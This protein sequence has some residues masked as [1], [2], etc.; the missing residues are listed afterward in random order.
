M[1]KDVN[2]DRSNQDFTALESRVR[3]NLDDQYVELRDS[4]RAILQAV[5]GQRGVHSEEQWEQT[6][7]DARRDYLSGR[8]LIEQLGAER[9]LEPKLMATLSQLRQSLIGKHDPD[10]PAGTMLIDLIVVAYYNA[11]RIQGYIGNLCLVMERELFGQDPLRAVYGD[12][13]GATIEYR[14]KR[15]GEQLLPLQDRAN[16]MMVRNLKALDD[17]TRVPAPTVAVGRAEQVNVGQQQ[18]NQVKA[19]TN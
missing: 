16:R 11:V 19:P 14:L 9:F 10:D 3:N 6:C 1:D 13:T 18:I 8:F 17:L 12:H 4:S 2:E 15:L 5:K 7:K